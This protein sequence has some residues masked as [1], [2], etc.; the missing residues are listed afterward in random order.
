MKVT[1]N[2]LKQ[3][4]EFDWSPEELSER[5]TQLGLEVEGVEQVGG[6]FEGIVVAEVITRDPHPDADRLSVCRVNDGSGERQIVC[7]AQNFKA[8]DKVPLILPGASLP[9]KAGEKPFTIKVGKIRGVESHGMMCSPGEIGVADDADGLMI[10]KPDAVVG[11]PFAEYMGR[12]EADFVYDLE[13]TPNRPDL[14]SVIGIAR[15]IGALTGNPLKLP[16]ADVPTE[17]VR[18]DESTEQLVGVRLDDPALCP[19]YTAR[20]IK[21]VKV[22]PSPDWLRNTLE[23][24]GVRSISNVVDVTNFVMLE[25]GQPL[26]AFDLH[27]LTPGSEGRPVVVVRRAAEG[28]TF[29]TLDER[30]HT[31]SP[32]HLLIADETK[33][34]ALAGVMGGLNTEINDRTTDVLIESAYFDP[35]NIRR[36]SKTLG[37]RTDS[38]YR[39]ERGADVEVTDRASRRAV[40]LIL[41]TAGGAVADGVVDVFPQPVKP[42]EVS[43]RFARS[44]E[45]L[46]IEIPAEEQVRFLERLELKVTARTETDATFAVPSFRVDLKSE[47]DLIEEVAILFGV[48]NIPATPPRGAI[49][50]NEHDPVYDQ[51]MEL[52]RLLAGIGL[53]EAQGQTLIASSAAIHL[54]DAAALVR[55]ANPLSADMDALRPSL[56]PGLLDALARNARH[57]QPAGQLFEIGRIFTRG[58]QGLGETRSLG[59]ALTG[60]RESGHP[61]ASDAKLDAG[62]LKGVVEETLERF[63]IRGVVYRRDEAPGEFFVESATILL[64]GK[65]HLGRLG[66]LHPA[67]ARKLDLRDG[68]FLAELDVD[69]M[70]ARR[71]ANPGFKPLPAYPAVQRD[72]ALILDEGVSHDDVL[73]VIRQ[74]KPENL[75]SVELFDVFR[76]RNIPEGRKSVAY[77]ITYR[78]GER[79]L[80]DAEVTAAQ[81]KIVTRLKSELAAT[82]RDN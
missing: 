53:D 72:V 54:A 26:H 50:T 56:L 11:Q 78:H 42:K 33:G 34:V 63:G 3:Y 68:V 77:A 17:A 10:L 5:L 80:K 1:L 28:E 47:A 79:T 30:E 41:E 8:G 16:E 2:W 51:L 43:L 31:L 39:F 73:R 4:V 9:A 20:I 36:T 49:G 52:R 46:G 71:N 25:T 29:T 66:R 35:A 48:E 15:Q 12:G 69:Q 6:G 13:V 57:Q 38:S 40:R 18:S 81:E 64:G 24:V 61:G 70:L 62:D 55:L 23:K 67:V 27:L 44:N 19:R 14:N 37:L 45:L 74:A 21:G 76:G 58:K 65:L 22:G 75:E 59:V 32:E 7:G 60:L 82:I